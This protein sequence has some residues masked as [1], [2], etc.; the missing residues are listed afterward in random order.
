M[1]RPFEKQ[2]RVATSCYGVRE[3]RCIA[4][5]VGS[6]AMLLRRSETSQ[7]CYGCREFAVLLR[8]LG[9]SLRYYG[10]RKF[11]RVANSTSYG[12]QEFRRVAAEVG[13][14]SC[15][16]GCRKFRRVGTVVGN[17]AVLAIGYFRA[18]RRLGCREFRR[19]ASAVEDFG[20]LLELLGIS[21]CCYGSQKF[22]RVAAVIGNFA[23]VGKAIVNLP[24]LPTIVATAVGLRAVGNFSVLLRF[25]ETSPRC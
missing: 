22:R 8:L 5:A 12:S 11:S 9:I 10:R 15:C 13:N 14:A 16:Y 7:C 25:S 3:F 20:V 6:F 2:D 18:L 1:L 24:V 23:E 4:R 21:P 17:L 19:V